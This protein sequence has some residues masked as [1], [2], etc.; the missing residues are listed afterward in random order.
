MTLNKKIF[1]SKI[2]FNKKEV[3]SLG[4]I[5]IAPLP[6]TFFLISIVGILVTIAFYGSIGPSWA[7][8]FILVFAAMF[9]AS[10][11]SMSRA[12]IEPEIAMDAH[13]GKSRK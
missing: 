4:K 8:A 5:R 6:S 2:I 12:P 10:L 11:I 7:V 13:L 1:I 3:I 9:T